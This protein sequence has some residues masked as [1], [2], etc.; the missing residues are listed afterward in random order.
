MLYN[1]IEKISNFILKEDT[2]VYKQSKIYDYISEDIRK[3]KFIN[4]SK[5]VSFYRLSYERMNK[6]V[7]IG[8]KYALL[9]NRKKQKYANF[10][11]EEY[12]YYFRIIP[13]TDNFGIFEANK[14]KN[15]MEEK[16]YGIYRNIRP[17]DRIIA[18]YN[19][20]G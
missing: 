6:A 12:M 17:N 3:K 7:A 11:D 10:Y 16:I 8:S 1:I 13:Y 9:A 19:K 20:R 15:E 2:T 14:I 4:Y 18:K 5:S